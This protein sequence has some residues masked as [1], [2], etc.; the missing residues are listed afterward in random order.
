MNLFFCQLCTKYSKIREIILEGAEVH[1]LATIL[2]E[3]SPALLN[4]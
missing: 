4:F 2:G 3:I 1:L